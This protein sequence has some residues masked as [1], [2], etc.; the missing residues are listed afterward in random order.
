MKHHK[1]EVIGELFL[2][3]SAGVLG[4]VPIS[5]GP[6]VAPSWAAPSGGGS[7]LPVADTTAL[8]KG[9]ADATKLL[10]IEVDGFSTGVTRVATPPNADFAMAALNVAQTFTAKQV[11]SLADA[12]AVAI[13]PT[14]A[15]NPTLEVKTDVG[16]AITGLRIQGNSAGSNVTL[17][18]ISTS[19]NEGFTFV[20][21]GTGQALF[22]GGQETLPG[23]AFNAFPQFGLYQN[24]GGSWTVLVG[25][26][27]GIH[28][29]GVW[30]TANAGV[31][32]SDSTTSVP[33]TIATKAEINCPVINVVRF[34]DGV[35]AGS[36]LS[37]PANS[38]AAVSG[39]TNNYN[40]GIASYFQR[41]ITND[42]TSR[43]V[44]GLTF[45]GAK[46]DGQRHVIWNI[47]VV[48]TN[49]DIVLVHEG[50]TSTAA[51]RFITPDGTNITLTV[52]S[53]AYAIYDSSSQRWRIHQ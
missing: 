14:G 40:P 11:L 27:V 4:D 29:S 32:W 35:G 42:A 1:V 7:T 23:I 28:G 30:I 37:S 21:K 49:G 38:P 16:S 52:G 15:S 2:N 12:Q 20:A 43:Q 45:T 25:P 24:A 39:T 44:T 26:N 6:G 8:V 3:G 46:Q 51:N 18:V 47:G 53:F 50:G 33:S 5:A 10:R 48:A 36:T 19:T 13:G 31:K 17:Q 9:S 34:T 41:W 22:P